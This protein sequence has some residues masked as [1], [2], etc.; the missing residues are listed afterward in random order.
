MINSAKY[1]IDDKKS[2]LIL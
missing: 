1:V 2:S